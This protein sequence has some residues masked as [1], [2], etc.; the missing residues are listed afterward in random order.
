MNTGDTI[1]QT[2]DIRYKLFQHVLKEYLYT[3]GSVPAS[4]PNSISNSMTSVT[5]T[6]LLSPKG[7]A[8]ASG[9]AA[10]QFEYYY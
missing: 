6:Q 5:D 8:L 4:D 3:F 10:L 7:I 2:T 9:T 1:L